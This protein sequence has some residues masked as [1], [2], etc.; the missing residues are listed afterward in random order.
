[1]A[2]ILIAEDKKPINTLIRKNLELVEHTCVSVFDGD[3]VFDE[4]VKQTFDLILLDIM[5]PNYDGFEIIKELDKTIPIIF[6][7]ARS[8]IKD[9]IKGLKLGADDYII[10]PFDMLELQANRTKGAVTLS[11]NHE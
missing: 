9:R 10:K 2:N 8:A 11:K 7:T 4:V 3:A 6:P 1:M 5:M